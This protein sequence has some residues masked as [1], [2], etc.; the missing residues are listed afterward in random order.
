MAR[1]M[2]AEK[3][4]ITFT[5]YQTPTG[6]NART[7]SATATRATR[8][9]LAVQVT[10]ARRWLER[11]T[12]RDCIEHP[13]C[14]QTMELRHGLPRP[15]IG[16]WL[17]TTARALGFRRSWRVLAA[18]ILDRRAREKIAL[19][20]LT[21]HSYLTR[22]YSVLGHSMILYRFRGEVF[23]PAQRLHGAR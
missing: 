12:D 16:G 22:M 2:T 4:P 18:L 13:R 5:G 14:A 8:A 10:L 9:M 20:S 17:P 19:Q 1:S 7:A 15:R 3:T 21:L 23:G 6:M 11:D